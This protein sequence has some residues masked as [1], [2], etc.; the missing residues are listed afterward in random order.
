MFKTSVNKATILEL[1]ALIIC[2]GKLPVLFS[3]PG[4][5]TGSQY[6][7]S[8]GEFI[9]DHGTSSRV[10]K[11][12]GADP[13]YEYEGVKVDT[14]KGTVQLSGFVSSD[15][16]KSRA[17]DLAKKVEGVTEVENNITVKE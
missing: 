4:C 11:A 16:Q 13:K 8:R 14:F 3:V 12:P 10:K 15:E 17:G 1:A 5:S 7:Q 9:D 6:K 2:V